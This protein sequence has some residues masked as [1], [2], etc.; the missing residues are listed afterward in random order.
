MHIK[1]FKMLTKHLIFDL[2]NTLVDCSVYYK[3]AQREFAERCANRLDINVEFAE[4]VLASIDLLCTELDHG[5]SRM[6]FPRSFAAAS[7]ALD[8]ITGNKV[9]ERA[10]EEAYLLGDE[11]F[12]APYPMYEGAKDVLTRL[13]EL[14]HQ[15]YLL[16]KGDSAVQMEKVYKNNLL[17]WFKLE[18]IYVVPKKTEHSIYRI[19]NDHGIEP[20]DATMIGD[21]LRDDIGSAVKAGINS[22]WVRGS[23]NFDWAYENENH[24]PTYI[25]D[26]VMELTLANIK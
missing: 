12:S 1:L 10:S 20:E 3:S 15:L 6:R 8:I 18:R 25:V 14:D 5:F 13:V 22:I 9:D 24:P 23:A 2:D 7:V 11:V 16:T 21:S 4:R 17:N 26:S 19:L